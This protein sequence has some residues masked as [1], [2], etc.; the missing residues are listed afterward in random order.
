MKLF[1]IS[2]IFVVLVEGRLKIHRLKIHP[3][4]RHAR[5]FMAVNLLSG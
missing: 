1:L 2:T 4:K 3:S 5:P